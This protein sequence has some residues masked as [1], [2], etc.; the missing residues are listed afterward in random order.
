M[1]SSTMI[2]HTSNLKWGYELLP[3]SSYS[4]DSAVCNFFLFLNLKKS[5]AMQKFELLVVIATTGGPTLQ[6]SLFFRQF[7]EVRALLR[8]V[9]REIN[10]HFFQNFCFLFIGEVL[11]G[12]PSYILMSANLAMPLCNSLQVQ[13][14]SGSPILLFYL[15]YKILLD[16][17]WC[18]FITMK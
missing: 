2:A 17:V 13:V 11:V 14:L 16:I 9:Y 12:P 3:Y 4:P 15:K 10:T 8:Q 5:L 7:K 18:S 6:T 1:C